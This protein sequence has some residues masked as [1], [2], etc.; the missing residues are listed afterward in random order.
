LANF[1]EIDSEI[2]TLPL[3]A[4]ASPPEGVP[5][6]A[7]VRSHQN[8]CPVTR[9]NRRERDIPV[10]YAAVTSA[11]DREPQR[12]FSLHANG[13][14]PREGEQG[15]IRPLHRG[16]LVGATPFSDRRHDAWLRRGWLG[17]G[18]LGADIF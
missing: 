8:L 4:E 18:G 13:I 6:G 7:V 15:P 16:S 10:A 2:S 11:V 3:Q 12:A 9:L 17:V 5:H 14:D 1:L